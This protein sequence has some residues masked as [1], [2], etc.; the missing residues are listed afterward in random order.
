MR[1]LAALRRRR[2]RMGMGKSPGGWADPWARNSRWC[3][4]L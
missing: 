1:N 3:S 4:D 2:M